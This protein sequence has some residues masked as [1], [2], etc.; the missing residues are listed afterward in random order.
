MPQL[1]LLVACFSLW[2]PGF[3]LIEIHWDVS[4]NKVALGQV[5]CV[6]VSDDPYHH[7]VDAASSLTSRLVEALQA[8]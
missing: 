5:F 4:V 6:I 7:S 2:Q 3:C 1:R 8:H